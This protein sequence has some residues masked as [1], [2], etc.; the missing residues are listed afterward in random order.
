M[1]SWAFI[2]FNNGDDARQMW[3]CGGSDNSLNV[4]ISFN[5]EG[6]KANKLMMPLPG[7]RASRGGGDTSANT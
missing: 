5:K 6:A 2:L 4:G 7:R 1:L 3:T